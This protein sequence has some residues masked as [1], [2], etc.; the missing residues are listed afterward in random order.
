MRIFNNIS[1]AIIVLALSSCVASSDYQSLLNDSARLKDSLQSSEVKLGVCMK[2]VDDLKRENQRLRDLNLTLGEEK[3]G[4][5]Y[6]IDASRLESAREIAELREKRSDAE[7]RVRILEDEIQ[8]KIGTIV[9]M[10]SSAADLEQCQER[11]GL[12]EQHM[13]LQAALDAG[14]ARARAHIES[15]A[16]SVEAAAGE[17]LNSGQA[18]LRLMD[19]RLYLDMNMRGIFDINDGHLTG[20]ARGMING[21]AGAITN[22][23]VLIVAS[24]ALR[25]EAIVNAASSFEPA[26]G[27][28][29]ET[30]RAFIAGGIPA[31]RVAVRA[32]SVYFDLDEKTEAGI[33]DVRLEAVIEPLWQEEAEEK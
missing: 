30:A 16:K 26:S 19:G 2:D 25:E 9:N 22:S 27:M 5:E 6:K 24:S 17:A 1:L 10:K 31:A 4:L 14:N 28:A 20:D 12:I 8:E 13:E 3:A 11:L 7:Y 21:I 23:T 29:L 33:A 18:F 15:V 32:E